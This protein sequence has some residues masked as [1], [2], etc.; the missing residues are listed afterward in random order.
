MIDKSAIFLDPLSTAWALTVVL[1]QVAPRVRA[2]QSFVPAAAFLRTTAVAYPT[3]TARTFA[4]A[5]VL[6]APRVRAAKSF[7]PATAVRRRR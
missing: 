7:V 4:V 3:S 2:A 5:L 1:V 6:V